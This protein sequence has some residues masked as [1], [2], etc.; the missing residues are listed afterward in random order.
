MSSPTRRS[1]LIAGAAG[2]VS[3]TWLITGCSSDSEAPEAIAIEPS[4]P[5]EADPNVADELTL[6][7]AYLGAIAA[8]PELR[9]TLTTIADQ[10]RAHARELGASQEALANID[11]IAPS[12][13]KVRPAVTELIERER[14]AAGQRADST[15]ANDDPESVRMLTYIAASE[16]SHIPELQDLRRALKAGS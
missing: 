6:I 9:G 13:A 8:F 12:A 11:P 16:T 2:A 5:P 15:A 4:A 10:H 7:G 14:A 3:A 1:L